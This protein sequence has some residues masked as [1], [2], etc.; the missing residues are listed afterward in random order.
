M[1]KENKAKLSLQKI[2]VTKLDNSSKNEIKGGKGL[3]LDEDKCDECS[4]MSGTIS[5]RC[6]FEVDGN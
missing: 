6:D 5:D 4:N 3:K 1:K 2:K